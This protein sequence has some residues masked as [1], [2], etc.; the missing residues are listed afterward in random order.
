MKSSVQTTY[1]YH[2]ELVSKETSTIRPLRERRSPIKA[3]HFPQMAQNSNLE[4]QDSNPDYP[5]NLI[6]C[7]LYHCR[8]YPENVSKIQNLVSNGWIFNWA[9]SMVIQ[10]VTK[11]SSLVPFTTPDPSI[12]FHCNPFITF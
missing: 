9:I 5:P 8:A 10:I 6:N 11:I 12:K 2:K 7:S 3:A 1:G 4:C